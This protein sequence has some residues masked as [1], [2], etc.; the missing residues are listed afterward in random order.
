MTKHKILFLAANPLQ[1][2]Q[3]ALDEE[4]RAVQ[5]ALERSGHRDKFELVTRWAVRPLDLLDE[6]RKLKPTVVHFSGHGGCGEVG[7]DAGAGRGSWTEVGIAGH[8]ANDN[9]PRPGLFFQGAE[10]R[11][12]L[13]STAALKETFG[14]AGRSVQLVVLNACYS[15]MQADALLAHVG[16]V[17]GVSGSIDDRAARNFSIGFYGGLGECQ[18]V[19]AAYRQGRAA[20][21]LEG[22]PDNDRPQ[23]RVRDGDDAERLILAHQEA[24]IHDLLIRDL[25]TWGNRHVFGNVPADRWNDDDAVP[26]MPLDEIYVEPSGVVVSS[27]PQRGGEPLLAL[28]ERFTAQDAEPRVVVVTADFGSGKS[29]SARML[30]CR[31]ARQ[32]L[33]MTAVPLDAPLPVYVRCAEDFPSETVDLELMVRRAWRRQADD[34]GCSAAEDDESFVWPAL[35]QRMVCLLDGLDEVDLGEQHL[36]SLFQK[37]RGKT[38]R[39]HRFVIFS[40]PG[41]LPEHL[42]PRTNVVVIHVQPFGGHQVEQWLARW[43]ELHPTAMPITSQEL[44]KRDLVSVA[45]TPILLFMVAFTWRHDA[46]GAELSIAEIYER[47]FQQVA[48]GKAQADCDLHLPI[49]S[50]SEKLLVALRQARVLGAG[51]ER[52]DAMLWLMG[53]VAWEAHMLA[54]RRPPETLSRW[55]VDRL[56]REGEVAIPLD[57]ADA[58]RGGL[59]LALQADLRSANHKF[60][61]GHKSF[62]EFLVGRHWAMTLRR[63]VNETR[64]GNSGA[65]FS[66]LGGRLLGDKSFDHL[67]QLVNSSDMSASHSVS[68]LGWSDDERDRLLRWAQETFDDERL[69]FGER[70]HPRRRAEAALCNDQRAELRE[71]ALAIGSMVRG[72]E[73]LCMKDPLLLR[74]MLAWFWLTGSTAIVI[75]SGAKLRGANLHGADLRGANLREADLRDANLAGADL[76]GADLREANLRGANLRGANL[77]WAKLSLA[78]LRGA[79]LHGADLRGASVPWADL[80]AAKLSGANLRGANLRGSELHGANLR[81]ANL[82]GANLLETNAGEATHD[83]NTTWPEDFHLAAVP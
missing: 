47:F 61:F 71:A 73:G 25:A 32:R 19:A 37:L 5:V 35:D 24:P 9:R 12:Q 38:T 14:A 16:C 59:V 31:W 42:D 43:N 78:N 29:L 70:A 63:L 20:I 30:A 81:G 28:I 83:S 68:P 55:H 79:D 13:V 82:R 45:Q 53:R 10:N 39:R 21:S 75:A 15:E 4:A 52:Q 50:A 3:L 65:A 64:T 17:V 11:P 7:A 51:A 80:H 2:G 8:G 33:R 41:V 54:Q 74:S 23:L 18:S 6:L 77:P 58:I 36:R 49:A 1:M 62:R 26:F 22:M 66:L 56:L 44:E 76:Y 72:S 57:A 60:L 69:Q 34:S 40:R 46:T 27:G 48:L 67:M